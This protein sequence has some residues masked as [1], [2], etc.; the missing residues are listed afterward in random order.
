MKKIRIETKS[1]ELVKEII[2]KKTPYIVVD[3]IL[4]PIEGLICL[5]L[6]VK[7]IEVE[8]KKPVVRWLWATKMDAPRMWRPTLEMYTEH[9]LRLTVGCSFDEYKKLEF[10]ATEFPE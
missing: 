2:G 3:G 1:G 7:E 8:E 10:S 5:G 4:M 9:E 6:I